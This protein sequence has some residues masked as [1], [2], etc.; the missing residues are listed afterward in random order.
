MI[1]FLFVDTEQIWRG[2]QDQLLS[3]L[4][5]LLE[6]GH[7][8]HL[9]CHP[10]TLLERRAVQAGVQVHPLAIPREVGIVPYLRLWKLLRDHRPE[11]LAFNTPRPVLLGGLVSRFSE[12]RVRMIFRR[13]NFPLRRGVFTRIKY[14]WG[15]DCIVAISE[16][17]HHQLEAAGVPSALIRTVYEGIDLLLFPDQESAAREA[18]DGRVVVGTVAHL[19]PEKGL[20]HL[21][22]AASLIPQVRSRLR[23]VIVGDGACRNDLEKEVAEAGLSGCFEF[24]GFQRQPLSYLRS[25]DV[26]VLPSLSEGLSSAILSAMASSLPVVA[27]SVGGI[28]E[29]IHHGDNGLL[30][31]PAN[32]EKLAQAIDALAAEPERARRMGKVGRDRVEKLF[33]LER[34]IRETEKLCEKLLYG[35]PR[36]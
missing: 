16:S 17:I 10:S 8:V 30:V 35:S 26:F 9:V 34:K 13:V 27:T 12:A 20:F 14:T 3:L 15:I 11:I 18:A 21:V 24:T 28:P 32:P 5:G 23:F 6:R 33:T 29:L 36:P 19:S 31:P 7:R 22:R 2:G 4:R 1:S 25:F